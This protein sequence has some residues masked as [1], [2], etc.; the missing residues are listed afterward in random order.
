MTKSILQN[1]MICTSLISL[2][3]ACGDAP[4]RHSQAAPWSTLPY[5]KAEDVVGSKMPSNTQSTSGEDTNSGDNQAD[6]NPDTKPEKDEP[7]EPAKDPVVVVT[8][9]TPTQT[10]TS[11]PTPTVPTPAEPVVD[12]LCYKADAFICEIEKIIVIETNKHRSTALIHNKESSWVSRQWSDAQA[13]LGQISHDGFPAARK[14]AL[15]AE[16]PT[17]KW[18][19]YAENVAM[20]QST[21]TDAAKIAKAFVEMWWNSAG[22]KANILGNY[23]SIGVGVSKKGNSYYATQ[24]FY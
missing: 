2:T 6:T 14:A 18:S 21:G 13:K 8:P 7:T 5:T 12:A 1:L 3:Q 16:F 9:A 11:N 17:A 20:N 23:K 24:I 19:F 4:T 15:T 22:H 10:P